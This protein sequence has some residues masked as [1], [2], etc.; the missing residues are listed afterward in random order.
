LKGSSGTIGVLWHHHHEIIISGRRARLLQERSMRATFFKRRTAKGG[1][2]EKV[3]VALH[4]D[5]FL[6]TGTTEVLN[7]YIIALHKKFKMAGGETTMH[8]GLDIKRDRSSG[9]VSLGAT[10]HIGNVIDKFQIDCTV[11][12]FTPVATDLELDKLEGTPC[13]DRALHARYRS[14]VGTLMFPAPTC[15]PDISYILC[16]PRPVPPPEPP[17]HRAPT[18]S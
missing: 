16:L 3:F 17:E 9:T 12:V 2:V 11:P 10:A 7:E 5:D 6:S 13:T 1:K 15:R 18:C 4:V 14:V 8:Y